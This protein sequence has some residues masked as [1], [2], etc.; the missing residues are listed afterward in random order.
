VGLTVHVVPRGAK[1]ELTS[2]LTN[3]DG[4]FHVV[5]QESELAEDTS[6]DVVVH[7]IDKKKVSTTPTTVPVKFSAQATVEI[8]ADDESIR[9]HVSQAVSLKPGEGRILPAAKLNHIYSAINLHGHTTHKYSIDGDRRPGITCPF[10]ELND[11]DHV[12]TDAWETLQGNP[13]ASRRFKN[14]LDAV[15]LSMEK[16]NAL[17]RIDFHGAKWD[18]YINTRRVNHDHGLVGRDPIVPLPH[19][20]LLMTGAMSIAGKD[21]RLANKYL[22]VVLSQ[23]LEFHDVAPIY[24][25]CRDATLGDAGAQASVRRLIDI[26][27]EDCGGRN[28]LPDVPGRGGWDP[29]IEPM[30]PDLE[31]M[32][33][34]LNDLARGIRPVEVREY[35]IDALAPNNG[36]SGDIAVISGR[37]FG[38]A[39]GQVRFVGS[40]IDA[41]VLADPIDWTDSRIEV[42]IPNGATYG[43]IGLAFPFRRGQ[44]VCGTFT[45]VQ[46]RD[47]SARPT[48]FIGGP[49]RL[50]AISFTKNNVP[51]N[52]RIETVLPGESVSLIYENSPN[53]PRHAVD[54]RESQILLATGVF[55]PSVLIEEFNVLFQG[56][57][58]PAQSTRQLPGTNY[59]RSTQITCEIDLTNHCGSAH[60]SASFIVHRP[61][62]VSLTGI[63]LTQATQFF[64][65]SEH[66]SA[67]SGEVKPDNSVMLIAGK[68]TLA[69]VYYTTDQDASFNRGRSFGLTVELTAEK[70]GED[71]GAATCFNADALVA[72]NDN[73]VLTQRGQLTSSANFLLPGTWLGPT[74]FTVPT[75]ND[76]VQVV[77]APLSVNARL[78][79]RDIEPWIR[80]R[81]DPQTDELSV[82][83]LVFNRART[84]KVVLV[85]YRIETPNA[86]TFNAPGE[87]GCLTALGQIAEAYP[88]DEL[89]VFFPPNSDD[90]V[91][92]LAADL[93]TTANT[94]CGSG[95]ESLLGDLGTK[96]F[97]TVGDDDMVWV[98]MV[99]G[100]VPLGNNGCGSAFSKVAGFPVNRHSTAMQEIGHALGRDHPIQTDPAGDPTFPNYRGDGRASIGEFG[101]AVGDINP[102]DLS[103]LNS[104]VFDPDQFRDFMSPGR[105]VASNP[106]PLNGRWVSPHT[107]EGL[108]ADFFSEAAQASNAT[109]SFAEV[110]PRDKSEQIVIRGT[111]DLDTDHVTLKP[112]FHEWRSTF[113]RKGK[114]SPYTLVLLND[115]GRVIYLAPILT[116][117]HGAGPFTFYQYAP[118]LDDCRSIQVRRGDATLASIERKHVRPVIQALTMQSREHTRTISWRVEGVDEYWCTVELTCD[119]GKTWIRLNDPQTITSLSFD[120]AKYGGGDTCRARVM[121]TDGFNTTFAETASF[122]L[123]L[124]PPTIGP[125]NFDNNTEFI[126]GRSYL[127]RVA[128]AYIVGAPHQ[129]ELLW[130]LDGK[131]IGKGKKVAV[132]F[133]EGPHRMTIVPQGFEHAALVVEVS[134][135]KAP[136]DRLP[137][138]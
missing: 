102:N 7:A 105:P 88:T 70:D 51:F 56:F 99:R 65:T 12:L 44:L 73:T 66:M 104:L 72:S 94:G 110:S 45:S 114:P 31:D 32:L 132:V 50:D 47:V 80:D 63:E 112:V 106:L 8:D 11:F 30:E 57:G 122:A 137:H 28:P 97:F 85:R 101:V 86:G 37:G 123:P 128:A 64:R 22:N 26:W 53:A 120:A 59:D 83:S 109:S 41:S 48:F 4:G 111:I 92:T 6:L 79:L 58:G 113:P 81:I 55:R 61:A 135:G 43:P 21:K 35:A 27:G 96:A 71:L 115:F 67:T 121:V 100:N 54:V 9:E 19:A 74:V 69:R 20:A 126:A 89:E 76:L 75:G 36:C 49:P 116:D 98:G 40:T 2:V 24:R 5:V 129:A 13:S 130:S 33:A 62:T 18:D 93:T 68:Q 78:R 103:N 136:A 133:D 91:V 134:A 118:Y 125:L 39:A 84:L 52:P 14:S 117:R 87:N 38:E 95:W 124:Q 10:P 29:T 34:C 42:A 131:E 138:E 16:R 3:E 25:I 46:H 60:G 17:T 119:D 127:L 82:D 77:N 107:Y 1:Q 108:I 15:A 23:L 90:R